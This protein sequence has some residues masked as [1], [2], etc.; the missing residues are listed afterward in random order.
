MMKLIKQLKKQKNLQK[1][2]KREKKQ[3]KLRIMQNK[4]V[5]Q[6]E[7]SLTDLGDKVSEEDKTRY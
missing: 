6:T 1:K 2:I 5:Y 4:L 7:K 3:L